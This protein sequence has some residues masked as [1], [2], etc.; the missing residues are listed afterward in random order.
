MLY[1]LKLWVGTSKIAVL[2]ADVLVRIDTWVVA[3]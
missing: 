1:L 2:V 3:F